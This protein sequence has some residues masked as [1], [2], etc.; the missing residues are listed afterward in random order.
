MSDINRPTMPANRL[1]HRMF[2]CLV[3]VAALSLLLACGSGPAAPPEEE[4]G[5]RAS[6]GQE[7]PTSTPTPA[8]P[9]APASA[10]TS[11]PTPTPTPTSTPQGWVFTQSEPLHRAAFSG[12]LA[13]IERLL[14]QGADISAWATLTNPEL[15]TQTYQLTALHLAAGFNPNVDVAELLLEWGAEVESEDRNLRMTPLHWA[16][17]NAD[18]A[19]AELLLEWGAN[20]E[21]TVY[22]DERWTALHLAAAYN[23][24]PAVAELLL[25][26]GA[27]VDAGG[28][29]ATPL[30]VAVQY[31]SNVAVAE[32][33]IEQGANI[34]AEGPYGKP[35]HYA[36]FSRNTAMATLLL[37][38][39]ANTET[40]GR[41]GWT[42]LHWAA[43]NSGS[44][45]EAAAMVTLLLDRGADIEAKSGEGWTPLLSVLIH[46]DVV[47]GTGRVGISSGFLRLL[48]SGSGIE[49]EAI[50][51]IELLLDRGAD[52][53][54]NAYTWAALSWAANAN[55]PKITELLL[56][57][58]ADT[59]ARDDRNKTACQLARDRGNFAGTPLL[60][61]L[62]R[63]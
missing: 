12:D 61:R 37:D 62:C 44:P 33:L 1:A 55:L 22:N 15:G 40:K 53:D 23:P 2:S 3:M 47:H 16:A 27:N 24:D 17:R 5:S 10:P 63:P 26:W 48:P 57:R 34:E 6:G 28:G 59:K 32:F 30:R 25:E 60:G 42:P 36:V 35:L 8:T 29:G 45:E 49:E 20:V 46:M 13:E 14:D 43:L 58:G 41:Y 50:V 19:V 56:D 31:N 11:T 52:I 7:A 38:R 54:A 51:V 21:A 18:P 4:D 39:G 9:A